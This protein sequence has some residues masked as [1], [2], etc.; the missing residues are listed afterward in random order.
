MKTVSLFKVASRKLLDMCLRSCFTKEAQDTLRAS[1]RA[2]CLRPQRS[3][4]P[5]CPLAIP[6]PPKSMASSAVALPGRA[7]V[8]SR[9]AAASA[10]SAPDGKGRRRPPRVRLDYDDQLAEI[11]ER[12]K[13]AK[14]LVKDHNRE[15]RNK[16][17]QKSRIIKKAS[18]LNQDDLKRIIAH[19]RVK[20]TD[21]IFDK[22]RVAQ[23][24]PVTFSEDERTKVLQSLKDL[25]GAFEAGEGTEGGAT[26]GVQAALQGMPA[27]L[28]AEAAAVAASAAAAVAEDEAKKPEEDAE[29]DDDKEEEEAREEDSQM[30]EG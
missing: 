13:Q 5:A 23:T 4:S 9:P 6:L 29:T 8:G 2:S 15:R 27:T 10:K 24:Q 1:R 3:R 30:V 22:L 12:Q 28:P 17:R 20:L 26:A 11:A 16:E 14:K 18:V 21:D 19:K 7:S 25:I